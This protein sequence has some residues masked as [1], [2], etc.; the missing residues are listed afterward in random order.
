M[1]RS[2]KRMPAKTIAV[3][4]KIPFAIAQSQLRQIQQACDNA[5]SVSAMPKNKAQ[6]ACSLYG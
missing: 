4:S 5:D 3:A 1:Y 2:C 6:V